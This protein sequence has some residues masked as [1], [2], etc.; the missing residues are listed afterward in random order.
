MVLD[1]SAVE[2]FDFTRKS[3][4]KILVKTRENVGVLSIFG[5]K[6]DLSNSVQQ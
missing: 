1:F 4:K 3:V 6:F 2:N 5:Q